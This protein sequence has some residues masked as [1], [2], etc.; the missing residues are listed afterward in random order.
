MA[1]SVPG[2]Q[3]DE[4]RQLI[5]VA[6]RKAESGLAALLITEVDGKVL[7]AAGL[8]PDL[9]ARGLH[10]GNW[11]KQVAPVVGGGGG[12]KPDFA[13]AGGKKPDQIPQALDKALQVA[14]E[15]LGG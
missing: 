1:L 10:A 5:D 14:R 4:L 13:Q 6:R 11:L 7:L 12:G 8:T 3:P 2:V 15:A 9:V